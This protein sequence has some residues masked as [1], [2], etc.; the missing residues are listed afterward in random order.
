MYFIPYCIALH[1][2]AL[3][4]WWDVRQHPT[5]S[6]LTLCLLISTFTPGVYNWP[7]WSTG[8]RT[9][10]P[11]V[12]GSQGHLQQHH[13]Q[14]CC[15]QPEQPQQHRHLLCQ[16]HLW[17]RCLAGTYPVFTVLYCTVLYCYCTVLYYRCDSR[18][19]VWMWVEGTGVPSNTLM[20]CNPSNKM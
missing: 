16:L 13:Q 8:A 20:Q 2:I 19:C 12:R 4:S 9:V 7:P 10:P 5:H 6:Q 15:Q 18:L 14:I 17:G 3:Q 11:R 1:C